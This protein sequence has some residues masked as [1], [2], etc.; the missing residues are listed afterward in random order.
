MIIVRVTTAT[1]G[2]DEKSFAGDTKQKRKKILYLFVG[3]LLRC[4]IRELPSET[5]L[6]ALR[7]SSIDL[8]AG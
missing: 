4:T 3:Q 7:I 2:A 6:L 1:E 8:T 5:L